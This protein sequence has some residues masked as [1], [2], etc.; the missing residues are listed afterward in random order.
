M[1]TCNINIYM[2]KNKGVCLLDL[3]V[4]YTPEKAQAL[5]LLFKKNKT[6]IYKVVVGVYRSLQRKEIAVLNIYCLSNILHVLACF[7]SY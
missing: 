1:K 2:K 4:L 3:H 7:I 6:L 5:I